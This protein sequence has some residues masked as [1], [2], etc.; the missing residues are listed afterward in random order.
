[1]T[2]VF[3]LYLKHN[4]LRI[5]TQQHW[6]HLSYVIIRDHDVGDDDDAVDIAAA[7]AA[8]A[9]AGGCDEDF[10]FF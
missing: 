5:P 6:C 1:M 2:E 4:L 7:A 3:L 9:A 8:A 10:F